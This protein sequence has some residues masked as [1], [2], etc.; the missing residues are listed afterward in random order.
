LGWS[1]APANARR[2]FAR[3]DVPSCNFGGSPSKNPDIAASHGAATSFDPVVSDTVLY[4]YPPQGTAPGTVALRL[5]DGKLFSNYFH[6]TVTANTGHILRTN[7][8]AAV[9]R[10]GPDRLSRLVERRDPTTVA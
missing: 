1:S 6:V 9:L 10:R 7:M 4:V 3:I 8:I 2:I 5:S